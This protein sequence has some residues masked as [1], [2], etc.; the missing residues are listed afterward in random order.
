M[1]NFIIFIIF[2]ILIIL[3]SLL[4]ILQNKKHFTKIP[5]C[6]TGGNRKQFTYSLSEGAPGLN[7]KILREKLKEHFFI[8]IPLDSAYADLSLG[9]VLSGNDRK[10]TGQNYDNNFTM[11]KSS[12]KNVLAKTQFIDNKKLMYLN[13]K[14]YVPEGIKFIPN[15][16]TDDDFNSN[17]DFKLKSN[18]E[19][20]I[21]FK[22]ANSRNQLG[23]TIISTKE[24]LKNIIQYT[25]LLNNSSK[26]STKL[27]NNSSKKPQ[28]IISKYITNPLLINGL[29]FNMRIHFILYINNIL[30]SKKCNIFPIYD[31][32]TTNEPYIN[33][34]WSDPNIHLSGKTVR[35][36][37]NWPNDFNL[38]DSLLKKCNNSLNE[39]IH[40]ICKLLTSVELSVYSESTAGFE[41]FGVDIMLDN[42][43]HAWLLEINC[44]PGY[45]IS[46]ESNNT[47]EYIYH[48]HF[49]TQ[50]FDWML[51]E[52]IIPHFNEI[53]VK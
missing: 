24:E 52:T 1:V 19:F 15:T 37:Y 41:I 14:K 45:S 17:D 7:F 20:P 43:G 8:E 29:K 11:Q 26:N 40:I 27:L 16:F 10:L 50:F 39:C 49:S 31:I 46:G 18:I 47:W 3:L 5:R 38:S 42:T 25:K 34:N 53:V 12:L 13:I 28:F 22:L 32:S 2:F 9:F 21:I 44:K 51:T 36:N 6:I 30:N 33:D 23:V 35:N 48:H 4:V